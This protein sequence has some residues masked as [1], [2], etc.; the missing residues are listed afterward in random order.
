MGTH[1][2]S[3]LFFLLLLLPILFL[4]LPHPARADWSPLISRLVED[5]FE[6]QEIRSLFARPEVKFEP[7]V[8]AC[9]LE[10][11]LR[12]TP[13]KPQQETPLRRP[14][15]HRGFLKKGVLSRARDYLRENRGLL[16]N[17]SALYC[18]PKEVVVSIMLVE[19]RLGR[20]VG[21]GSAFN[22]LASMALSSDLEVI[23]PFLRPRLVTPENEDLARE[24][25]R[26]KSDWAYTELL[27]LLF[28]AQA[29]GVDPVGIPGSFYG[30]IGMC[31]FMPS[32]VFS[33]GV[34]ADQDGRVNPFSKPDAL[35]SIANYLRGH[36]WTC[37]MDRTRQHQVIFAYNHSSVY[38][39]TVLA[40]AD[41]LKEKIR[42]V[43]KIRKKLRAR[44]V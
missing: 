32:N 26:R 27:S 36:G 39:N 30:A 18:V 9:K 1:R 33:Y 31:Q 8:M 42:A 43:K 20:S 11:L 22:R 19:T 34:D 14:G 15:V 13:A 41:K 37:Q 7:G 25:C 35:H 24:V 2:K 28:Y 40:V 4:F 10:E 21:R 44:T 29:S 38:V 6:E 23:R 3:G 17:I 12:K 16:E 5:G